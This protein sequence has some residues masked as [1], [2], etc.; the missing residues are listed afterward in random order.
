MS[1]VSTELVAGLPDHPAIVEMRAREQWVGWRYEDKG[2][3]KPTKVPI[4][5]RTGVYARCG[6]EEE[7]QGKQRPGPRIGYAKTNNR[8]TW[9]TYEEALQCKQRLQLAGI[10]Y[11]L[12]ED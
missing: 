9:G 3:A 1:A 6:N 7:L 12:S 10:G 11:V 4:D 2:G 5:P 8:L